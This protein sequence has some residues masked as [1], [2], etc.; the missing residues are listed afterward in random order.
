MSKARIIF[1]LVFVVASSVGLVMGIRN[2][3]VAQNEL[4]EAD[5]ELKV[6]NKEVAEAEKIVGYEYGRCVFY[7]Q[8]AVE[9]CN[10]QFEDKGLPLY[11]KYYGDGSW[12]VEAD[13]IPN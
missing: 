2:V 13:P 12:T 4:A 10:V 5:E 8:I 9:T 7:D 6:A 1:S 11:E 3:I